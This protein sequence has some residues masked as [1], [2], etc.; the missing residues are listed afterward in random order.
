MLFLYY[1]DSINIKYFKIKINLFKVNI[2]KY[3]QFKRVMI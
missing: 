1:L 2:L 3:L